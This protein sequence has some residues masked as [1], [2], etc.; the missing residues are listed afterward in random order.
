MQVDIWNQNNRLIYNKLNNIN[1][2]ELVIKIAKVIIQDINNYNISSNN[3]TFL[4]NN[5]TDDTISKLLVLLFETDH[6]SKKL[7]VYNW[8]L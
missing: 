3:I 1:D 7:P 5:L 2:K 6:T 8:H 4:V